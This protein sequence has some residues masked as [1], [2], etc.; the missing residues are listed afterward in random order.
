[1]TVATS[2]QTLSEN[3]CFVLPGRH[4]WDEFKTIQGVMEQRPGLCITYLGLAEQV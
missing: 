1:M 4:R 2:P 3:Q